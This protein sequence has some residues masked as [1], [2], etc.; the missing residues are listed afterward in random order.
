ML[1]LK[2]LKKSLEGRGFFADFMT[3]FSWMYI[4]VLFIVFLYELFL[5]TLKVKYVNQEF[6]DDK[7]EHKKNNT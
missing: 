2:F 5:Y 6:K 4:L 1:A 3:I 7:E